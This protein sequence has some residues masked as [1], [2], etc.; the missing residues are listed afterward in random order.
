MIST[1]STVAEVN[2]YAEANGFR[3]WLTL[4]SQ[5]LTG[6]VNFAAGYVAGSKSIIVDGFNDTVQ[7]IAKGD[8]FTIATDSTATV[9]TVVSTAYDRGTIEISFF[10]GLAESIADDDAITITNS[11]ASAEQTRSVVVACQDIIRYH[12]Q[13]NPDGTLWQATNTDLNMANILQAIHLASVLPMRDRATVIREMTSKQFDDGE[14]VIQSINDGSLDP[15]AKFYVDKARREFWGEIEANEEM[16][17]STRG[18][19]YGR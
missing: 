19:Y 11:T 1:Y 2:T 18:R 13:I 16:Y 5:D 4:A 7:P 9:Y 17:G 3:A 15:M 14:I 8:T 10:P 6:G 12:G